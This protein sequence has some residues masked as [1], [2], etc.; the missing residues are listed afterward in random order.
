MTEPTT[1]YI[2]CGV[3]R[4][5]CACH[6]APHTDPEWKLACCFGCGAIYENVVFPERW[7]DIEKLLSMRRL[8]QHRNWIQPETFEELIAEQRAFGDPLPE[9]TP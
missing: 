7:R 8:Q 1:A 9:G 6:E 4:I 2:G 3:W 5:E